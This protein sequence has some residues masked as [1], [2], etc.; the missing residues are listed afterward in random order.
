MAS[1]LYDVDQVM[2]S[3]CTRRGRV[4]R[5]SVSLTRLGEPGLRGAFVIVSASTR[6][7]GLKNEKAA[8]LPYDQV[9]ELILDECYVREGTI[10]MGGRTR[11]ST[12]KRS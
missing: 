2:R 5:W 1:R 10:I 11:V 12:G 6:R 9:A 8:R 4:A 7:I 3:I